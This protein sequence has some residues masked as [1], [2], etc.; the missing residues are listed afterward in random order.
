IDIKTGNAT[1]A[2]KQNYCVINDATARS[3]GSENLTKPNIQRSIQEA[4]E[5]YGLTNEHIASK[6]A[7]LVNAQKRIT[8]WRNGEV[9]I[10]K[11]E[12][13]VSAVKAGLEFVLRFRYIQEQ[14]KVG[15]ANLMDILNSI[16]EEN[17]RAQTVDK[18]P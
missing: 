1:L 17:K 3:V 4:L 2:A 14:E 18:L 12:I 9:E 16:S 6:I 15:T 7:E 5:L 13:D 11:E 8:V 10:I